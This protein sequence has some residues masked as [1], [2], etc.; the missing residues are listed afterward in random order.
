MAVAQRE[1]LNYLQCLD[2]N[3]AE[4]MDGYTGWTWL[5]ALPEQHL[6]ILYTSAPQLWTTASTHQQPVQCYDFPTPKSSM[7]GKTH[8][9][10]T[11]TE[12]GGVVRPLF[13]T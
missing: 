10:S 4:W 5:L 3:L 9:Q 2:R 6:S 7:Q 8:G 1:P 12:G 11:A 13:Q